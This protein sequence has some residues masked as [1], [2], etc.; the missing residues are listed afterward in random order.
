MTYV[1]NLIAARG[2]SAMNGDLVAE[3][4]QRLGVQSAS[5]EWLSADEA[6]DIVLPFDAGRDAT[7]TLGIA[8]TLLAPERID[9]NAV[10]ASGRRKKLLIAD[11]DSTIIEQECIDELAEVAGVGNRIREITAR[12]MRGELDFV[13]ALKE[14]VRLLE[15][16]PAD[17]IGRV[18]AERITL[19]TGGRMLVR[20]MRANGAFAALVSGG[21]SAFTSHVAGAV[22][23]DL[24]RA[25]ELLVH[26]GRLTGE[27]TEPILGKDAKVEALEALCRE[28]GIG[29]ED[30]IAVGDGA[31]DIPMLKRAGLGI[32]MHGKPAVREAAA[33][34]ID[35]A[36]LTALLYLQGYRRDEFVEG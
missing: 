35:H 29:P 15:G 33:C 12:A 3:V 24:H 28:R 11:M 32:A 34:V 2:A 17:V 27:V 9:A 36:D 8:R 31:N 18:I 20:T 7:A 14:R 1:L 26:G 22:G 13:P 23:F 21:F 16:L 30:V 19:R 10:P 25:N 5:V 4:K 6:C